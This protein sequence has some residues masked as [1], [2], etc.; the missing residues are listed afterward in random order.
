MPPSGDNA[1]GCAA[2]EHDERLT[3]PTNPREFAN[4]LRPVA[5]SK[6]PPPEF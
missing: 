2:M 3:S 1:I 5:A 4:I 6:L